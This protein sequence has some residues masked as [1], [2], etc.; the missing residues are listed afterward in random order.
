MLIRLGMLLS[1]DANN[2]KRVEIKKSGEKRKIFNSLTLVRDK[3]QEIDKFTQFFNEKYPGHFRGGARVISAFLKDDKRKFPIY[4]NQAILEGKN[5]YG[6]IEKENGNAIKVRF[7][8]ISRELT[9][10]FY[11]VEEEVISICLDLSRSEAFLQKQVPYLKNAAKNPESIEA[12][13][14]GIIEK[15]MRKAVAAM[16]FEGAPFNVGGHIPAI[17]VLGELIKHEKLK[18]DK[19][20][21][22]VE[23]FGVSSAIDTKGGIAFNSLP[24]QTESVVSSVLGALPGWRA[25]RGDL[26][27]EWV[28]IRAVFNAGIRP[29]I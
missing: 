16:A 4:A 17:K 23:D 5:N 24:I 9:R 12:W 18:P 25:F 19:D 15:D 28:Q 11:E 29:S 13:Y 7:L 21:I 20:H 14:V 6:Y 1:E 2:K 22:S 26:D 8:G 10:L 27:A 3:E